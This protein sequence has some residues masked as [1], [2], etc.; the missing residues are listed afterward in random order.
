MYEIYLTNVLHIFGAHFYFNA[1]YFMAHTCISMLLILWC[2]CI[3]MLLI[4]WYTLVFQFCLFCGT[5]LYFSAAYFVVHTCILATALFRVVKMQKST[6][7]VGL[8]ETKSTIQKY[9]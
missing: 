5:H 8:G 9:H 6:G 4:L 1:D 7:Q 3:S 2:T